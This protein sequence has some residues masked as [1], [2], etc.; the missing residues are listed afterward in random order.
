MGQSRFV[1]AVRMPRLDLYR[2]LGEPHYRCIAWRKD[3]SDK[4]AIALS[5]TKL[6]IGF[7]YVLGWSKTWACS[8]KHDAHNCYDNSYNYESSRISSPLHLFSLHLSSPLPLSTTGGWKTQQPGVRRYNRVCYRGDNKGGLKVGLDFDGLRKGRKTT[9]HEMHKTCCRTMKFTE[10]R[11]GLS[12]HNSVTLGVQDTTGDTAGSS[13]GRRLK[14]PI[15]NS[16]ANRYGT[17]SS[18]FARHICCYSIQGCSSG[19]ISISSEIH[20]GRNHPSFHCC[21]RHQRPDLLNCGCTAVAH[22][23]SCL[24]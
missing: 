22:T 3:A 5:W 15:L 1:L 24:R 14:T 10:Q 18:G 20:T 19:P 2:Y 7:K 11:L 8:P 17:S 13:I 9:Q 16:I 12:T 4:S 6:T 23:T 21:T